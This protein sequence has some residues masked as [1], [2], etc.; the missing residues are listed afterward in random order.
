[1][2]VSEPLYP[3][4]SS[5]VTMSFTVKNLGGDLPLSTPSTPNYVIKV[6]ASTSDVSG[7]RTDIS[8]RTLDNLPAAYYR[9]MEIGAEYTLDSLQVS[10]A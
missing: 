9:P 1:M 4:F 2:I 10:G 6:Y 8:P 7:V 3:L 5:P